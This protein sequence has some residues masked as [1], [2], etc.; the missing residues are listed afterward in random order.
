MTTMTPHR[1]VELGFAPI[2]I[3][4]SILAFLYPV[5]FAWM[6]LGIPFMLG[7]IMFGM[8]ASLHANDFIPILRRPGLI[9]IGVLAQYGIMPLLGLLIGWALQLEPALI[10]GIVL[11]GACPGGTASNVIAYLARANV[12]LSVCL[13]FVSTLMAP[14]LTPWLTWLYARQ[15]I[16]VN[17]AALMRDI[18]LIVLLPLLAGL[19]TRAVLQHRT[20]PVLRYFPL[21][22][23]SIITAVIACVVAL[24]A[25]RLREISFFIALAVI[26]HNG[27]GLALG[28]SLGWLLKTDRASRRT[29]AIEVGMQ[30]SGLAVALALGTPAFGPMAA[31][32]GALFS[33]WHNL[34]GALLASRWSRLSESASIPPSSDKPRVTPL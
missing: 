15:A 7:V 32:P 30:N 16:E 12:G 11:L 25:E 31:L 2:A 3:L 9:A 1:L 4:V 28:Y 10:A 5:G 29:L 24:N 23:A 20:L 22:S 27:G 14:L 6:S 26:L 34:T 8:G 33:L 17:V 18:A 19:I 13:T 21:V